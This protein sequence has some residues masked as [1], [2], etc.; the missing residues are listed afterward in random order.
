MVVWLP[1]KVELGEIP[2]EDGVV[3]GGVRIRASHVNPTD[4]L[5]ALNDGKL[6]KSSG[7]H[8]IPRMTWWDHRGTIEWVSYRFPKARKL[9]SA[10]VYWFDDT[11]RGACR[12]PASWRL[13]WRDGKTWKPCKLTG[14]SKYGT[15]L[16]QF[17]K[18]TFEPVTTGELKLE[19]KLKPG[20]S[21]G[22]L[23]WQVK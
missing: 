13:L 14:K 15:T 19:V 2:G 4:T 18:V 1:E 22:I 16:N 8:G 3:S 9:S 6:P 10:A 12:V 5:T 21:G 11:G 23:E 20:F 17:N 7:D